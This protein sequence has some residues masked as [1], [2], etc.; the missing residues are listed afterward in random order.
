M[1]DAKDI[2]A[3]AHDSGVGE[4]QRPTPEKYFALLTQMQELCTKSLD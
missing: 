2:T 4:V 3:G 1:H